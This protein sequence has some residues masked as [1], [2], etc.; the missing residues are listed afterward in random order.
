MI[1]LRLVAAPT[2]KA[3]APIPI[4]GGSPVDV[5]LIF[6]HRTKTAFEEWR[7]A[8]EGKGD[9]ELV[10]EMA[11]GWD[12]EDPFNIE[13]VTTLLNSYHGAARAISTAYAKELLGA[14]LGN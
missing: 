7:K 6:T 14:R 10:M 13:S 12:L 5:E 11:T 2:F 1:K 8:S 4:P 3:K 9:V